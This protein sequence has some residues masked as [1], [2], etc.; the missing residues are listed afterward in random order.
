MTLTGMDEINAIKE[1]GLTENEANIY[2]TL[3][4]HGSLTAGKVTKHSGIHRRSIYDCLD[5]LISK[6]LV[7]Y[8][9]KGRNRYY[10]ATNPEHLNEIVKDKQN[11]LLRILPQLS[12]L[13]TTA[14]KE[15]IT[16]LQGRKG[17]RVVYEDIIANGED[18]YA[19][20]TGRIRDAVGP[21]TYE[22]YVQEKKGKGIKLY[23]LCPELMRPYVN[24]KIPDA[25]PRFIPDEYASPINIVIY[26][27][28]VEL[29]IWSNDPMS[30]L[31]LLIKNKK[32]NEA[33]KKYFDLL[34][35]SAMD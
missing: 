9:T 35:K 10:Q 24:I 1:L 18:Y 16:I 11:N 15:E 21:K 33:F 22:K 5:R 25:T 13:Y 32:V 31:I 7:S 23:V 6:G 29:L 17:V 30:P 12:L 4:T 34:W 14:R 8:V 28:T 26:G 27:D 20:A 2:L 3:L 19:I